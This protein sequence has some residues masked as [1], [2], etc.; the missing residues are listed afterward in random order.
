MREFSLSFTPISI[1]PPSFTSHHCLIQ[2]RFMEFTISS[3]ASISGYI[4]EFMPTE[5][6]KSLCSGAMY[7]YEST[8]ATVFFA[9]NL[10]ASMQHVML[11]DSSSITPTTRSA[12]P[13]PASFNVAIDVGEAFIVIMSKLYS[14]LARRS[15]L[16][17]T[18]T[19]SWCSR[20]RSFA[21]CVP[22]TPAPAMRIFIC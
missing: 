10:L 7:S 19:M 9:P 18:S 3:A 5:V 15:S 20:D 11:R 22:T 6:K 16:V 1:R 17:S 21:R 8:R 4:I 12:F 2:L 13:A 14:T